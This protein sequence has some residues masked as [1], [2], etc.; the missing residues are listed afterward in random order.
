MSTKGRALGR[1][2]TTGVL[3]LLISLVIQLANFIRTLLLTAEYGASRELDAFYLANSLT[4]SVFGV[5]GAAV[6]T[7]LI[8]E[9]V[10]GSTPGSVRA[11]E[12]WIRRI[13]LPL[14]VMVL[15]LATVGAPIV[16]GDYPA[17]QRFDLGILTGIL[18]IGQQ[19][20]VGTAV[21][22]AE[23]Q[24]AGK[25]TAT[26]LANLAPAVLPNIW[27]FINPSIVG[28]CTAIVA[29]YA[30]EYVISRLFRDQSRNRPDQKAADE[31]NLGRLKSAT[32][33]ILL[34]SGL[35]QTQM[36]LFTALAGWFGAGVT[37]VFSNSVQVVGLLQAVVV[38]NVI[39]LA[40]PRISKWAQTNPGYAAKMVPLVA[41]GSLSIIF[42]MAWIFF[43]AGVPALELVFMRGKYTADDVQTLYWFS[44]LMMITVPLGVIRDLM[45]RVLY[46]K[47]LTLAA[48]RNAMLV[49][50]VNIA[51]TGALIAALGVTAIF[52]ALIVG[53]IV[54]LV[55]VAWI[56]AKRE[57]PM[58]WATVG[59]AVGYGIVTFSVATLIAGEPLPSGSGIASLLSLRLILGLLVLTAMTAVGFYVAYR[60]TRSASRSSAS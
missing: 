34:S 24:T 30:V 9:L 28:M 15:L 7:V 13:S 54:S 36:M 39:A 14:T 58:Q 52:V 17:Q 53:G 19:F 20:R 8:P 59:G 40:Y 27:F 31:M 55:G 25:F 10:A 18:C 60:R 47:G 16:A 42:I 44:L 29:S 12:R 43:H 11:Y 5:I 33:P 26:R 1:M 6:T 4:V 50:A 37:T 51:V 46:A 38:Q 32:W 2:A 23:L 49:V 35:F 41:W 21:L 57:I 22:A 56:L 3:V 48:A 45:Y